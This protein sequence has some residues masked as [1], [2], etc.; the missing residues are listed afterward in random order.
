MSLPSADILRLPMEALAS[1]CA[2]RHAR[3]FCSTTKRAA[4][5][6]LFDSPAGLLVMLVLGDESV[7]DDDQIDEVAVATSGI[8]IFVAHRLP[9]T[10]QP[11]QALYEAVGDMPPFL[12]LIEEVRD[13]IRAMRMPVDATSQV[14]RYK[15]RR[16]VQLDGL[17]MPAYQ[18]DFELDVGLPPTA[19]DD[20]SP[21][22]SIPS[23]SDIEEE[24]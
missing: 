9:P 22:I 12:T 19:D 14:W 18:L 3:I 20:A 10:A 21:E 4:L 7:A 13:A 15:G 24:P 17:D 23:P 5:E 16:A 6:A 2:A 1:V 8:S 11:S